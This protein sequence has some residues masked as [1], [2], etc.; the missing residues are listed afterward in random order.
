MTDGLQLQVTVPDTELLAI[1]PG[2]R[3][4]P[5]KKVTFPSWLTLAVIVVTVRYEAVFTPPGSEI[6]IVA[7]GKTPALTVSVNVRDRDPAELYPVIV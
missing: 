1:H 6:E 2:I 3:F 7:I 5:E 4:E